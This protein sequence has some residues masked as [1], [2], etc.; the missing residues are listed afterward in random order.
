MN[1]FLTRYSPDVKSVISGFDRVRFRGTL[2]FL[3][4]L[5]GMAVWLNRTGV[6][7]KDFGEYATS[8]TDQLREST[9][10]LA[11]QANR[12]IEY[13]I[14]S[15]TRKE[16][17][18]REIAQRDG[19]TSGLV[20]VLTA[21]EPCMSFTV[22]PNRETKKLE[23][24]YRPSKCLHQ[25]FYLIDPEWGWL[26]VRLQTWLPFTIKVV[27]NGRERLAQQ[28]QRRG[29]E[30]ERR[31]NCFVDIADPAAA[32]RLMNQQRR[33][34]WTRLF[35]R[36]TARVHP[37][38]W[39][40]FGQEQ[41]NYYWSADETEWATD[42]LFNSPDA[43]ARSYP[44]LVQHAI[45]S[46]GG[47]EVLRFLGKSPHVQ[48]YRRGELTSHLGKRVEGLRVKHALDGNSVKM[49]DK[50]GSVLRVETTLTQTRAMKVYRA[51]ETDPEGPK[52]W[53][54]LR[55]GVA[56]LHRRAAISNAS[57]ERYLEGL[58]AVKN[59]ATLGETAGP[60]CSRTIWKG[61]SARA[62]NPLATADATLLQAIS[63]GEFAVQGF[64]NR[65]IHGLLFGKQ[66]SEVERKSQRAKVTRLIRLL[67]A[68]GLVQKV[69][70]T[71]RYV[72][73]PQGH[74]TITA[75][76]TARRTSTETLSQLA[77]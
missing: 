39:S 8:L 14:S 52:R 60:V 57:N 71:H 10:Q 64:R 58:A 63:R 40:M 6:L 41:L 11:E 43:L 56:D 27:L 55:K 25:Y 28:L 53:M 15:G 1:S 37:T 12:P 44:H 18:A 32:G 66:A 73:T 46:F 2:R 59:T 77:A 36:L 67:R 72:V 19:I 65:D 30:Y 13:Q 42:I 51:P 26:N 4:N 34:R 47:S 35:D 69:S 20:C 48:Q 50:Q 21:V 22:G 76:L 75:L 74:E 61:R 24:R 54:R 5:R 31:D 7:L 29:I 33:T 9:I 49:Y 17:V 62:L 45:T 16:T 38:H 70:R 3:A 68:H 23:L